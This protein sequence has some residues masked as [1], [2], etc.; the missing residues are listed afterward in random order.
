[1]QISKQLLDLQIENSLTRLILI[2][3]IFFSIIILLISSDFSLLY[4]PLFILLTLIVSLIFLNP[5]VGLVIIYFLV[6]SKIISGL[7]LYGGFS[8]VLALVLGAWL[9]QKF[10]H[11][12]ISFQCLNRQIFW[13]T[14]LV[15]CM[16]LSVLFSFN[17][18][19]SFLAMIVYLKTII[20]YFLTVNLINNKKQFFI[21]LSTVMVALLFSFFYGVT[22]LLSGA[23]ALQ[24]GNISAAELFRLTG[25]GFEPNFF[26]ATLVTFVPIPFLFFFVEK[27]ISRKLFWTFLF[28]CLVAAT[29]LTVSRGGILSLGFVML[30]LIIK[31]RRQRGVLIGAAMVLL[32]LLI[33]TPPDIWERFS[34]ISTLR[35]DASIRER[36]NL[37]VGAIYYF[38]NYPIFGIGIGNFIQASIHFI[39]RHQPAH[40]MYLEMGAETGLFGFISFLAL[41]GVSI[42]YLTESSKIFLKN[43]LWYWSLLADS[44]KLGFYGFLFAALFLSLQQ[45]TLFWSLLGLSGA[46]YKI[47]ENTST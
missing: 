15:A 40:N 46:L 37:L 9:F 13:T 11:Y 7:Q 20:L 2:S 21:I 5:F 3:L 44:L 38:T 36:T 25:L 34:T 10:T 18:K 42:R 39:T 29:V 4:V 19:V 16:F 17:R 28:S 33:L 32:L 47:A 41:I 43:K 31:K 14:A 30:L 1:M 23:I 8:L 27:K 24:Q 22:N 6:F 45:D 12:D 26:A 35:K